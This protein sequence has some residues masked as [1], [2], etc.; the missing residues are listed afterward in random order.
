MAT[1]MT[2]KNRN[3]RRLIKS[4]IWGTSVAF[5]GWLL[6]FQPTWQLLVLVVAAMV[7]DNILDARLP[8]ASSDEAH[9][10]ALIEA[11]DEGYR[12]GLGEATLR[13]YTAG[14]PG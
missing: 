10:K 6:G 9:A 13:D 12:R 5:L 11:E 2:W 14:K 1:L 7:I 8:S 4:L 3:V